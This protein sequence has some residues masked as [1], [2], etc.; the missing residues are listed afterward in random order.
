MERLVTA[1]GLGD[2][3]VEHRLLERGLVMPDCEA[4][5]V[6]GALYLLDDPALRL[7]KSYIEVLRYRDSGNEYDRRQEF[8]GPLD[9]QLQ[10][11]V[12]AIMTELGEEI[13]VLGVHRHELPRVPRVVVR[14]TIANALAHRSYELAGTSIRVELRPA[15]V[16]VESPGGLPEPVTVE[17]MREAQ[18]ARNLHVIRI[19]RALR[20]AE[21]AGRGIDVIQDQMQEEL[22]DAPV[23]EDTG[24]S[25]VVS[26]PIRSAVTPEERAWVREVESRGLIEPSDRLLLVQASR[27][28]ALTNSRV[29]DLL[30]VDTREAR[31]A[32]QRLAASGF[33]VRRGIRGG[34]HYVLVESLEAPAGLRLSQEDL[35]QLVLDLASDPAVPVT[36]S[37]VRER[38]GL[39][40]L[41]VLRLLDELVE[42][43]RL[44]RLGERRGTRYLLAEHRS[45]P[46]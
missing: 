17:N 14:E 7:G 2:G 22:L 26:L 18:S 32:L 33:L 29:R 36:N 23:F 28:I 37:R 21:D 41:E 5:S 20:L 19:L 4:L 42:E 12:E 10:Q 1:L 27:G 35:K 16:R 6:A 8:R 34:T 11:T 39:K 38:T 13:V 40:R 46:T 25:V 9:D 44:I 30:S 3:D 31:R 45:D 24:H 15:V 43:G